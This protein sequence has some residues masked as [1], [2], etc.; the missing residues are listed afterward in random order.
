MVLYASR[1]R[2]KTPKRTGQQRE[3]PK[4]EIYAHTNKAQH[5]L[6]SRNHV[7]HDCLD[8]YSI[9]KMAC[10]FIFFTQ[11][12]S[13]QRWNQTLHTLYTVV[14]I[15]FLYVLYGAFKQTDTPV[16]CPPLVLR[17]PQLDAVEESKGERN[18]RRGD[19]PDKTN[20]R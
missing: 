15:F 6:Q 13:C 4:E 18:K 19:T 17:D 5:W 1:L 12:I 20:K 2:G 3:R 8:P 9:N 11:S 14:R 10:F 16:L 7:A